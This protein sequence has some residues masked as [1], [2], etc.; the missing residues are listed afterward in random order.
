[1]IG[2][3]EDALIL[4]SAIAGKKCSGALLK[5]DSEALVIPQFRQP[6]FDGCAFGNGGEKGVGDMIFRIHPGL[7]FL[8]IIV[9]QPAKGIGNFRAVVVVNLVGRT[10]LRIFDLCL[11]RWHRKEG[12][13][14]KVYEG[15]GESGSPAQA[16]LG[17]H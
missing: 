14:E 7:G 8:G 10:G 4:Q 3:I 1:M 17:I 9:F 13:E 6:F 2:D 16:G 5:W 15:R 12:E 11:G